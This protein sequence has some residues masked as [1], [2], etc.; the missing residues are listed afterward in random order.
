M[1][2][3]NML[4]TTSY[5]AGL[6]LA[7]AVASTPA[8]AAMVIS[9]PESKIEVSVSYEPILRST[10]VSA[11]AKNGEDLQILG[12][13]NRLGKSW[14]ALTQNE[15][16]FNLG[17]TTELIELDNNNIIGAYVPGKVNIVGYVGF[18]TNFSEHFSY[19]VNSVSLPS[20]LPLALSAL[21]VMGAIVGFRKPKS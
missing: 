20:A 19:K 3:A 10:L 8:S 7:T 14:N 11:H 9:E 1:K 4:K 5:A 12:L 15:F 13:E 18:D 21:G 6:A 17:D 2:Q 16:R